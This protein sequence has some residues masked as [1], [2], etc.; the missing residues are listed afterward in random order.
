DGGGGARVVAG[1]HHRADAHGP[2]AIEALLDATLDDVGEADD[3]EELI[4]LGHGQRRAALVGDAG[5]DPLQ[6]RGNA[7][8][9][10]TDPRGDGVDGAFTNVAPVEIA[11]AHAGVRRERNERG[12]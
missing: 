8:A 4:V 7:A 11:A 6:L 5:G 1:D 12:A 2:E 10:G 3:A 9:V